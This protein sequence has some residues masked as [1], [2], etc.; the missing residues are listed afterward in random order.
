MIDDLDG[1]FIGA[2][3]GRH[4]QLKGYLEYNKNNISFLIVNGVV[5]E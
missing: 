1:C 3:I 5:V 2:I 4:V